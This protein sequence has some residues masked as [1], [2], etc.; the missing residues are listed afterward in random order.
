LESTP[1]TQSR[2]EV[3]LRVVFPQGEL[4]NWQEPVRNGRVPSRLL[5]DEL[6]QRSAAKNRQT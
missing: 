2:T 4:Y 5:A 1:E 3:C 6:R